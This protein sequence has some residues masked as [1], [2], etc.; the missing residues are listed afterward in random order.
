M[1][2]SWVETPKP[3]TVPMN[4]KEKKLLHTSKRSMPPPKAG[5]ILS[6]TVHPPRW[7]RELVPPSRELSVLLDWN[8][9]LTLP[10]AATL[11]WAR[12]QR[13]LACPADVRAGRYRRAPLCA[14]D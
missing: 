8:G 12:E 1:G 11:R 7:A 3:D 14:W 5:A 2:S 9:Q 13:E 6:G 10:T 4:Y